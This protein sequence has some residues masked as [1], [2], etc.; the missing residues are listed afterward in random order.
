MVLW[1]LKI[2]LLLVVDQCEV[3]YAMYLFSAELGD[4]EEG[5][6]TPGFISEFHFVPYQTEELELAITEKF[7]LCKSVEFFYVIHLSFDKYVIK[8]WTIRLTILWIGLALLGLPDINTCSD[9]NCRGQTPAQ[10]EL[11]YLNKAKWLETYG[12]DR[13]TVMVRS[14]LMMTLL[15]FR[16]VQSCCEVV[17]HV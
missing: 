5:V 11:N 10:A 15:S 8:S 4:Y 13:H 14:I 7:K 16:I 6:H 1:I 2:V 12:V 3:L 9:V 17:V